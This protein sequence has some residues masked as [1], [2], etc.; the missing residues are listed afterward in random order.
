MSM[1]QHGNTPEATNPK[2]GLITHLIVFSS[3]KVTQS[4]ILATLTLSVVDNSYR[5]CEVGC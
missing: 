1:F 2:M 3:Y 4:Q 5:K